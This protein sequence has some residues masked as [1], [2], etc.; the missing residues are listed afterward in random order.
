MK[1]FVT[2]MIATFITCAII[3][4]C[5]YAMPAQADTFDTYKV[6]GVVTEYHIAFP[7][8]WEVV[9][10]TKDGDQFGWFADN[11]DGEYWHIGDLVLIT[12]RECGREEDDEVMDVLLLG[13]LTPVGMARWL[14]W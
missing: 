8:V 4:G 5:A 3:L 10:T 12:M 1:T 13:E 6:E 7:G 2:C 9:A 14:K 11:D